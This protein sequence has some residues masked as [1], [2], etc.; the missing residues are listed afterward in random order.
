MENKM[1][2]CEKCD[3]VLAPTYIEP[4]P[5]CRVCSNNAERTD[6]ERKDRPLENLKLFL[7]VFQGVA[8]GCQ[9][10]VERTEIGE[11]RYWPS[12]WCRN[13]VKSHQAAIDRATERLEAITKK[14]R[15]E[16]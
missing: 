4:G 10:Y 14:E 5:L 11:V 15:T 1:R 3:R 12:D 8:P 6:Q 16:P 13:M 2:R 7:A 9:C